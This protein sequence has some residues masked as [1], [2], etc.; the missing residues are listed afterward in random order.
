M[1]LYRIRAALPRVEPEALSVQETLDTL[2]LKEGNYPLT[3]REMP[4]G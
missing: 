3:E 4:A 2:S 1:R